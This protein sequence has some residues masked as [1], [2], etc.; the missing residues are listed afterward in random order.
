MRADILKTISYFLSNNVKTNYFSNL[1]S[2]TNLI[3]SQMIPN[4][5]IIRF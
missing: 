5:Q 4:E 3:Y 1:G 2:M